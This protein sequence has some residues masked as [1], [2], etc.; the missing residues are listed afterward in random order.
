MSNTT[1]NEKKKMGP[2]KKIVIF[3]IIFLS[4]SVLVTAG[5]I[6]YKNEIEYIGNNSNSNKNAE[7]VKENYGLASLKETYDVNDIK[8]SN[9]TQQYG[10]YIDEYNENKITITYAQISG[11]KDLNIQ[12]KIN[13]KIKREAETLYE[14]SF[15]NDENIERVMIQC[16]VMANFS[17]VISVHVS[18][19]ISYTNGQDYNYVDK[20]LNYNLA[21]GEEISF[22][23][24]FTSDA[25]IKAILSQA[26]YEAVSYEYMTN[27]EEF[28]V[29]L[30]TVDYSNIEDKVF[31]ILSSYNN[32]G[33]QE[34][35]FDI[36]NIYIVDENIYPFLTIDMK[37]FYNQIAIYNR[38]KSYSDLYS[39][40]ISNL[41]NVPCFVNIDYNYYFKIE[42]AGNNLLTSI[43]AIEYSDEY[44][45]ITKPL[46]DKHIEELK[47]KYTEEAKNI[48]D[49]EPIVAVAVMN[50][51]LDYGL[52]N[53]AVDEIKYSVNKDKYEEIKNNK[54]YEE[55]RKSYEQTES[56]YI[57]DSY[58]G[59]YFTEYIHSRIVY[60]YDVNTNELLSKHIYVYLYD[61]KTDEHTVLQDE[62]LWK[63]EGLE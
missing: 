54:I 55:Y 22:E 8:Y 4:L 51:Y 13:Q 20:G 37:D 19:G 53:I 52:I 36:N 10:E 18:R 2:E 63:G 46:Y 48:K 59:N 23:K 6:Y 39:G 41:K 58:E 26:A 17:N 9:I 29:D 42:E 24:L 57:L 43:S 32:S 15:L 56:P 40:E 45:D 21:T 28:Y 3:L 12:T 61:A 38:Y 44:S 33:V 25:N 14:Y 62:W 11:L 34:F 49:N 30:D 16:H 35:Y 47:A 7:I 1:N 27:Y 5:L 60:G 31:K 50:Y